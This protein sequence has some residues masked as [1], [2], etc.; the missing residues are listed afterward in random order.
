[1][2]FEYCPFNVN[3]I[4]ALLYIADI[5]SLKINYVEYEENQKIMIEYGV[6]RQRLVDE[7]RVSSFCLKVFFWMLSVHW[8]LESHFIAKATRYCSYID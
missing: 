3:Y 8:L 5:A 2:E 1:M 7:N 4:L 6:C